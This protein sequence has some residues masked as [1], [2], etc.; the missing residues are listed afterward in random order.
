[1]RQRQG[2][3]GREPGQ[4]RAA[5]ECANTQSFFS[6]LCTAHIARDPLNR[7]NLSACAHTVGKKF[8]P[9]TCEKVSKPGDKL[10]MHYTGKLYSDC[11]TFDSSVERG[12]PFSFTLGKGEVIKGWDDGLRGMC[13]GE[14]RK[15]T[16]PSDLAYGDDGSGEAIPGGSTLQFDV[17]LLDIKEQA[18]KKKR[19]KKNKKK[20]VKDEM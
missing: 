12:D 14:K 15:L 17:E 2:L 6:H 20:K 10:T 8:K 7:S 19:K 18:A 4:G 16:I 13:I 11:S 1:M 5:S 3:R 9:E